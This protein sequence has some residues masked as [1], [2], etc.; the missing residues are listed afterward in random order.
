MT[1]RNWPVVL[2]SCRRQSGQRSR[3]EGAEAADATEG[4]HADLFAR[5]AG[6]AVISYLAA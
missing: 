4:R 1:E 2:W 5:G 3:P 6:A